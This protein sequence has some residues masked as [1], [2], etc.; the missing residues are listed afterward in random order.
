MYFY[1]YVFTYVSEMIVFHAIYQSV[2]NE[3]FKENSCVSLG[4]S[5]LRYFHYLWKAK[6]NITKLG[7]FEHL[8]DDRESV[9]P[10]TNL[11]FL[12]PCKVFSMTK[13]PKTCKESKV[14]LKL[15]ENI[16]SFLKADRQEDGVLVTRQHSNSIPHSN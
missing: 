13:N 2:I 7:D 16:D 10:Q 14:A 1:V 4:A 12:V 9:D 11:I 8:S 15:L 3:I 5:C 6:F